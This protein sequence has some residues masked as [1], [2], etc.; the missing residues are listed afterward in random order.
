M[1]SKSFLRRASAFAVACV[2]V[3]ALASAQA[4]QF[5]GPVFPF[6][7][8]FISGSVALADLSGDGK[9]DVVAGTGQSF[10]AVFLGNG[11]G[12]FGNVTNFAAN[13]S[14]QSVAVGDLN[15]DGKADIVF[16]NFNPNY[17][18]VLMGLGGGVFAGPATYAT[19]TSPS[20]VQ[21]VDVN[22]DNL[23]DA[24]V[25]AKTANAV[26]FLAGNGAGGFAAAVNFT[27]GTGP[28]CVAVNDYNNDG[29]TDFATANLTANSVSFRLGDGL[30]GFG[31]NT[32]LNIS[33]GSTVS[34]ISSADFNQDGLDDLVVSLAAFSSPGA[35]VLLATG[36]GFSAATG[37]S[38]GTSPG[39]FCVVA[40]DF[41]GDLKPDFA[42]ANHQN[43][44][45]AVRLG[46]GAGGFPT[47]VSTP[48]PNKPAVVTTGDV[49]GDGKLD[50]ATVGDVPEVE[51]MQ[52]LGTGAFLASPVFGLGANT[53]GPV[54]TDYNHDGKPDILVSGY[55]ANSMFAFTGNGA[56]GFS[57]QVLNPAAGA[58]RRLAVSDLNSD[59]KVDYAVA[60]QTSNDVVVSLGT[61]T[62]TFGAGVQYAVGT[63][64]L[65]AHIADFN[66]DGKQDI[67]TPNMNSNNLSYLSGNGVG[68]FAAAVNTALGI[69]P[70]CAET[71]DFDGDGDTD[72]FIGSSGEKVFRVLLCDGAGAFPASGLT[73][74]S[75]VNET[76]GCVAVAD[77]NLDGVQDVA[78]GTV[79]TTSTSL[80]V[81]VLTGA[82]AGT[83][84]AYATI[85]TFSTNPAAT[86]VKL[87]DADGDGRPDL[88][89][90]NSYRVHYYRRDAVGG[91]VASGAFTGGLYPELGALSDLDA[92]G[93]AD[94]T[95]GSSSG[96]GGITVM[97]NQALLPVGLSNYGT[98]TT[99]CSGKLGM[100]A[101]SA[102]ASGN[103]AF[104][105]STTNAP[106]S[107]L[108]V[109]ILTDSQDLAGTD[110]FGLNL[111]MHVDF[112]AATE[113][114]P[115]DSYVDAA[116]S[117][118]TPAPIPLAPALV[119][120]NYYSQV[121]FVEPATYRCTLGGLGLVSSRGMKITIQP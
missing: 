10:A 16:G 104:A 62:A 32:N 3:S 1:N 87:G 39:A 42:T 58:P 121:L 88:F 60:N 93:R 20:S 14:P 37:H 109:C 11:E 74:V 64:P 41:N 108:G 48:A 6:G 95:V 40:G 34:W 22:G 28:V 30:G 100:G 61:G 70:Q 105:V 86:S 13:N 83:F 118:I 26:S 49:N 25:A 54:A 116:G 81:R 92:D 46:N 106:V 80:N 112:L 79:N 27:V 63:F 8:N 15:G 38:M 53:W 52:G 18:S 51:V 2:P 36:T 75:T 19:G 50:V 56:G 59:G 99:G 97:R 119:G 4:P 72:V 29:L 69:S 55:L 110:V 44:Q 65:S 114:I 68:G 102:P 73:S 23:L 35:A 7:S 90:A 89:F 82:G 21:L 17:I 57:A 9:V 111:L 12:S 91:F 43:S 120:K 24:I 85:S 66:L 47:L 67:V 76:H 5:P 77:V 103:L 101:N 84:S 33:V 78:V 98:G 71:A 117:A 45:I 115:A 113:I 107:S 94:L 31:A 96:A